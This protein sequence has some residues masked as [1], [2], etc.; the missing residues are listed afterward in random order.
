MAGLSKSQLTLTEVSM[1]DVGSLMKA[2]S[3]SH[4]LTSLPVTSPRIINSFI[5]ATDWLVPAMGKVSVKNFL[6]A[7]DMIDIA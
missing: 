6:Q 7:R 3:M 1:S 5:M 2:S 4:R